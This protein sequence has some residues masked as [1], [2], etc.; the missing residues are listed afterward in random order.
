M[1]EHRAAAAGDAR[2]GVVVDLDDEIVELVGAPQPVAGLAGRAAGP[3]GC[4][5]GRAGPR[6][7]RRPAGCGR[8]GRWVA[9]RG[10]RS[11]RH[12]SRRSRNVPRG[13][14]PSPSRL[15]ARIP[16]RPSATGSASG[17]AISQPRVRCPG[18][19]HATSRMGC[20]AWR[21]AFSHGLPRRLLF[22]PRMLYFA[23]SRRAMAD[24][25]WGTRNSMPNSRKIL[26]VD[27]DTELRDR[28][29]RAACAA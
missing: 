6:T 13:V 1:D 4:N 27:D 2:P 9:G 5:G 29:G 20:F 16:P 24:R 11:A 17:P 23:Q 25:P 3:A 21:L 18:L 8:T 14:P 26:I 15:L 10:A 22:Y 7:S 19:S 12:H 28:A